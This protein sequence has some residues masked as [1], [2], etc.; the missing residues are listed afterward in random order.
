MCNILL[1]PVKNG[2]TLRR[3]ASHLRAVRLMAD[4]LAPRLQA[5]I[6]DGAPAMP[7]GQEIFTL[8]APCPSRDRPNFEA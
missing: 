3:I 8:P 5:R 6:D 1:P 2:P 7:H 4:A